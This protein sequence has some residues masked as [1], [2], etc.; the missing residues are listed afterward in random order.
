VSGRAGLSSILV[1]M[2]VGLGMLGL[3]VVD[4]PKAVSLGSSMVRRWNRRRAGSAC[5]KERGMRTGPSRQC[6]I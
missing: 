2:A 4:S 5:D 1:A 3:A 6:K